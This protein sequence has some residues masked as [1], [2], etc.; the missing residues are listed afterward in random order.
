MMHDNSGSGPQPLLSN[1][2]QPPSNYNTNNN[3]N[4]RRPNKMDNSSN[5]NINANKSTHKVHHQ[6]HHHQNQQTDSKLYIMTNIELK[7]SLEVTLEEAYN[8]LKYMICPNDLQ[9]KPDSIS[10]NDLSNYSNREFEFLGDLSKII[11]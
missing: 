7:D 4:Q 10:F 11:F 9:Q 8:K 3:K 1:S 2:I 6:P 5:P